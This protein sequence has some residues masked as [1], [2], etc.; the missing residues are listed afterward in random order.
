VARAGLK[1][2]PD[3]TPGKNAAVSYQNMKVQMTRA[4]ARSAFPMEALLLKIYG[5]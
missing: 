2:A 5:A 3:A 4:S 1:D